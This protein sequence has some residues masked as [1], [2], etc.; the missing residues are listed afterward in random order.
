MNFFLSV[1]RGKNGNGHCRYR[2]VTAVFAVTSR[3]LKPCSPQRLLRQLLRG[4]KSHLPIQLQHV[5]NILWQLLLVTIYTFTFYAVYSHRFIQSL[6]PTHTQHNTII[7]KEKSKNIKSKKHDPSKTNAAPLQILYHCLCFLL[8]HT[9]YNHNKNSS[10]YRP[11]L[12]PELLS[13]HNH[14]FSKH[15]LPKKPQQTSFSSLIKFHKQKRLLLHHS[16]RK[17]PRKHSI[18]CLPLPWRS[19]TKSM[20]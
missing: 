1:K 14:F 12:H 9:N 10:C 18:R 11:I 7:N 13:K 4:G 19:Y 20:Q 6:T 15:N 3:F 17:Q 5:P 8:L 2:F 16:W